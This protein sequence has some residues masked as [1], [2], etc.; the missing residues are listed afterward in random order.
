MRC[1]E[2]GKRRCLDDGVPTS[3]VPPS[4][5]LGIAM[6]ERSPERDVVTCAF[7]REVII[8]RLSMVSVELFMLNKREKKLKKIIC[9]IMKDI[10][11][12]R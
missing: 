6:V 1:E 4:C 5:P 12:G 9:A 3:V 11:I 2:K 10:W 7:V 8:A